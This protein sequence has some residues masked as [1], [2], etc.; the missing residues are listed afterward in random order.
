MGLGTD[1]ITKTSHDIFA[2][3]VWSSVAQRA[4]EAKLYLAG[5]IYDRSSEMSAYGDVLHTDT[6]SDMTAQNK[7]VNTQVILQTPTE[8]AVDLT[9]NKH[10]EVSFLVEDVIAVQSKINLQSEYT[11]KGA[12]AIGKAVDSDI[13]ALY[14]GLSETDLGTIGTAVTDAVVLSAV[15]ALGEN[16]VPEEDRAWVVNWAF[17]TD[18]L[19]LDKFVRMDFGTYL[20]MS[21][22]QISRAL[23]SSFKGMLY[24]APVFVTTN[25]ATGTA[26]SPVSTGNHCM[27]FHKEAFQ[28]AMQKKV[29]TQNSYIQEYLGNLTTIDTIYGVAS[30]RADAGIVIDR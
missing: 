7:A 19:K 29:R 20:E 11:S 13:A 30:Y 4:F 10:K 6:I 1:G 5:L 25:L 16:N 17:W 3:E 2:P 23:R 14:S 28:I 15:Q 24:G 9:I 8:S 27:Y 12:Y 22:T 21:G 26:G 18:L